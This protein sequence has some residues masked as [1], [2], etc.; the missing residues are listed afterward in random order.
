MGRH[1][2]RTLHAV[3]IRRITIWRQPADKILQVAPD[4]GVRIFRDQQRG[5]GMAQKYM[6]D[7]NS[8]TT[9]PHKI[10]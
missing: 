7:S 5:A 4:V 8:H 1:V 6:T 10:L 3:K 2:I 9:L